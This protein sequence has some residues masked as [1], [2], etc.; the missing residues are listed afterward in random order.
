MK[1]RLPYLLSCIV[2]LC[3]SMALHAQPESKREKIEALRVSYI[4]QKVNF[5]TQEAQAF[6]PL[7]NEMSDRLEAAR[8]AFRQQYNKN[9][10]YDFAT[11]KEAEAYLAAELALKQKEFELYKEY[12]EK[13]KKILP[14]KKVAALRRAEEEFKHEIIKSLKANQTE[15]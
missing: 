9:T 7:Y 13:F 10:N 2:M 15:Q 5:T 14:I 8:K 12:Y 6:W 11:D 3:L 4:T 1:K